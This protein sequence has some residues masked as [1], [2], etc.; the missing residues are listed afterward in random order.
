MAAGEA[1]RT[2]L[3]LLP[4]KG[5][6]G[7]S[8]LARALVEPCL[9][10]KFLPPASMRPVLQRH[11]R[12]CPVAFHWRTGPERAM[13]IASLYDL[14]SIVQPLEFIFLQSTKTAAS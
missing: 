3:R 2:W 6:P 13:L 1:P 4:P 7:K 5:Y 9:S 12:S 11:F 10:F 14:D 8:Y